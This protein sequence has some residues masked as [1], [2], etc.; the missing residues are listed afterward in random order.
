MNN[1]AIESILLNE[2]RFDGRK[3]DDYRDVTIKTGLIAKAE[4]SAQCEFGKTKIIAG[5][6]M[7]LGTPFPDTPDEGTIIVNAE[8]T[9]MAS[10]DFESGPPGEDATE[11][12]RVVDRGIRESHCLDLKKLTVK[13]SEKVW[14]VFI[15]IHI[16]N[17]AGNLIDCAFL[18]AMA[19][20]LTAKVPKVKDDVVIYKERKKDLEVNHVPIEVTVCKIGSKLIVD[21]DIEEEKGIEAKLTVATREDDMVVALQ[22]QG[23]T[24]ITMKETKDMIELAMK[25]S[26][27]L[28]KILDKAVKGKK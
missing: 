1:F 21:T 24:G 19:A 20:L 7:G 12:A 11:L 23:S 14:S 10:P 28:R 13:G 18:A 27:D 26:K 6:K 9:P 8:F 15:D 5:V 22:K 2:K 3:L 4:G 16:I 17:H 25:K